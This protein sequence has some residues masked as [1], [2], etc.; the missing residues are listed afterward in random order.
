M[1]VSEE[2]S[3]SAKSRSNGVHYLAKCVLRGTVVLQVVQGHIRSP[4]SNDVVFGKETSIE[5]VVVD[6]DGIAQSICEQPVFGTIKDLAILPWNEDL[7]AR[8]PQMTGKDLLVVISDSGKLSFLTFSNE[9]HRFFPLTHIQLSAPGNSRYQVGRM[10][11]VDSS[12]CFIAASAYE[13]RLAMF[14]VSMSAGSDII[15]KRIFYP[16]ESEEDSSTSRGLTSICGTIWSM[17]FISRDFRYA[18][19]EHNPVLA[20]ILNR[21]GSFLNELLLLEWNMKEHA[22]HVISQYAEAGPLA[23]NVVE[24]PHSYGFAFL[25]RVGDA[26]LMDLRDA[27]NPCCVHRITLSFL[28]SSVEEHNFVEESCRVH[29]ADEIFNVA[30]SALLELGDLLKNDDPMSIDGECDN[31]KSISNHVCSWSWEPGNGENP[32]MIFCVDSGELFMFEITFDSNGPRVDL[33]ECLY[34]GLPCKALLWVED[35][36]LAALVEMGDGMVLKLEDGRLDYRSPIQNIAPILDISV[37]DYH[38]EKHDQVFACCGM[39]PEGSLRI[40]RSGISVE[41]LLRTAPIY[42][43]I[44][45]T[46]TVKMK[47]SDLYHS[48]LVLSFV[49]QTR[50]LSV[51]ISFTD[52][53]DIVGFQPD[54]C[55][56][57]CGLVDDGLLVQIYQNSVRLCLP[58]V[59][60]QPEASPFS[61]PI[62][63]SW[64]P[65]NIN[66]SLGAVGHH[67]IVVATSSPSFLFIL[68]VRSLSAC[69][70][71]VYEM[72]HVQLQNELSCVS[73]PWKHFE[74]KPL[75]S[76]DYMGDK[77][78][79]DILPAGVDISNTFVIGTH[80]PSVEV[81]SFQPNKGLQVLGVGSISLTNTVGTAISGCVPQDVR[82][83]LVDRLYVLSGLRNG[84]LL[85]FE[86]PATSTMFSFVSSNQRPCISSCLVNLDASLL[87]TGGF[88][89][90]D[91][92]RDNP[93]HLQLIAIRRIGITP[94]FLIPLSDSLDADI[95]ALSDRPWLLQTARHSLSYTSISFQ[96]STH[97]T[98]V[99]SVECPKGILFV[100]EN[101]LHL[102]EMVHTKRLNVQKFHLGGTP[103]KVLYH[104]ESRLLLVM[105]TELSHDSSSSDICCVDPLSGSILSSFRLDPGE[106][107]KCMDL[108]RVGNEQVLV[109][110]TSLSAGPAIMP[111]GE[112][113]STRGRLIVLCLEHMQNS[114]SASM[115]FCS[116]AGSS[117]QRTSPFREI[118]GYAAEQLSSS[119][120][121]SSPD[122]NSIEGIKVE[123][124]ESWHLRLACATIW[125]GMVL[126]VCPY[127]DRYFLAS[128]GNAFYVCGF[129]NDNSQRVRRLAVGRTRFM[130]MTLTAHFTRIAVGD[131]R[132]GILF[133]TYHEDA[134][135]LDQLYCDPVQ[136]L[137]ADCILM[138]V[139][140]AVVS[141]RKG[142]I[143]L[144]SCSNQL[145]DNASPERNLT[146]SCSFYMGEIAVSIRK[147]SFS[148]KLPADDILKGFDVANTIMDLSHNSIMASTLLGS[149]IVF[150][151]I[152]REEHALLEALQARLVVHPLTAPILGNDHNEFRNRES[153][154]GVPKI[155]DGDMLA[156][157]LELTS[158][159]QEAV[160]ELPLGSPDTVMLSSKP[161][162]SPA[163]ITVNQVVRLLER[164][165]YALN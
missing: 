149:I 5:L 36:F 30:A 10:L 31:L 106:T 130:I 140:T 39:A 7:H 111:S 121:C 94:A 150:I 138:D 66:I 122:D 78:V 163:P 18:S 135:K 67:L 65:D 126:A 55:T 139:D 6:E 47:A 132:D 146:R 136:R 147:G 97:V 118:V 142:S 129:P 93:V 27:H 53:T 133:Y 1:A 158:M 60:S 92:S 156:Q 70:W 61:S 86:W 46:W 8:S 107:G 4:S 42:Q 41:K 88:D 119:S 74:Q 50:V 58:I 14:S 160:L 28:P 68:G 33:S 85:R 32:R 98:P 116:K 83:V 63:T 131:C 152:S 114:D 73:I 109:I 71:E 17:C 100:A 34:K 59:A 154:A 127:L 54:V 11:A 125:P 3:S 91:K 13:D 38:D 81:L 102:V 162:S 15:D 95:I 40:I 87:K 45:G 52:V 26:L 19:K 159:Q 72:Q 12:G 80:K 144:L 2:E 89:L 103:R 157:F 104:S 165:H 51:G 99:S 37:M 9:M 148:Y 134:R 164:V 120:L 64:S 96:P 112:A 113:E 56:L 21:R 141:D 16:S 25:F 29:D 24:V 69:H 124:T 155:L 82:L 76:R 153:S 145:E 108:V 48:L 20:I 35:G 151:P 105:R 49:E 137:V 44:T 57:A 23:H 90:S 101:S 110:G 84:M 75:T 161:P 115:T 43:G 143:A 123:E 77:G 22:V 128:A 62:C 117:S 79:I